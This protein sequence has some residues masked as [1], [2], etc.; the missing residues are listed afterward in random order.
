MFSDDIMSNVYTWLDIEGK[1][2]ELYQTQIHPPVAV[3]WVGK[4]RFDPYRVRMYRLT[5]HE[6]RNDRDGFEAYFYNTEF[7]SR[8]MWPLRSAKIKKQHA[9]KML[10]FCMGFHSRLGKNSGVYV[11]PPE[12]SSII[13]KYG[14]L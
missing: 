3:P 8:V 11:M 7:F 10:P 13:H 14:V 2:T 6:R 9:A 4:R 12:I 1:W 5:P